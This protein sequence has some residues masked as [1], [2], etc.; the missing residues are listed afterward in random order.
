MSSTLTPEDER[1]LEQVLTGDLSAEDPAVVERCAE[2]PAFRRALE[3]AQHTQQRLRG[4]RIDLDRLLEQADAAASGEDRELVRRSVAAM[5]AGSRDRR[6]WPLWLALAAGLLL[7]ALW[8]RASW[9][10]SPRDSVAPPAPSGMLADERAMQPSGE[11][12]DYGRFEVDV[13]LE[14]WWSIEF[15]VY[16]RDGQEI[17]R[18]AAL[19]SPQWSPDSEALSTL[20]E[21]PHIRWSYSVLDDAGE[22]RSGGEA[23]AWR[24]P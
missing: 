7:G 10:G 12:P 9:F 15:V 17:L 21:L 6:P 23:S 4:I 18:S 24:K 22:V 14:A 20:N 16:D 2:S 3:E 5:S 8:V 1:V 13:E 19:E 11:V